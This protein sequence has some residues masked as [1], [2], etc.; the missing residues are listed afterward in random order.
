ME[1][2][3]IARGRR[4]EQA[5][6]QL[7]FERERESALLDQ[8]AE[9]ITEELGSQVDAAAFAQ[10]APEDV[11]IVR[12]AQGGLTDG[13][14]ED[15]GDEDYVVWADDGEDDEAE[16]KADAEAEI[17]RLEAELSECRRRQRAHERYLEALESLS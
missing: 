9:V 7:E 1:R 16:A 13:A 3:E 5:R 11:A 15:A 4:R 17:A 10:M 6:E 8:L 2:D 12:E 14:G